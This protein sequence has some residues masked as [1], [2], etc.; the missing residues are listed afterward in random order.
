MRTL[1]SNQNDV[2]ADLSHRHRLSGRDDSDRPTSCS[3]SR[4]EGSLINRDG[5]VV[6]SAIDRAELQRAGK[7]FHPRPSAAGD[8]GYDATNSSGSN[9]GP[10]NKTFIDTVRQRV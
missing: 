8:K 1:D 6:G 3:R 2:G 10:T 7:Y 9:L 5:H 4:R